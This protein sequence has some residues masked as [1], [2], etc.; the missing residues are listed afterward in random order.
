MKTDSPE[1]AK[2]NAP[3]ADKV[4]DKKVAPL[5][6]MQG[7][8]G[9]LGLLAPADKQ[10]ANDRQQRLTIITI[11]TALLI[12]IVLGVLLMEQLGF[13][14]DK[15][16][17][18]QLIILAVII[19]AVIIGRNLHRVTRLSRIENILGEAFQ[20][21]FSPQVIVD[22][23]GHA[24]IYNRVYEHWIERT[25]QHVEAALAAKF[26]ENPTIAAEFQKL[27][28]AART[29]TP[30][31]NE[32]PVIKNGKILEWRRVIVRPLPST[33][34]LVWRMEDVSERKRAEQAVREE[35]AKLVDFMAH[36]P[37]GIYSVDQN[38]RFRFVNRTLAE[39]LGCSIEE[40]TSGSVKL[41][42]VFAKK[43]GNVA[44]HAITGGGEGHLHGDTLVRSK[45]GRVF[46]VSITQTVVMNEDGKT[47]RTRSIVRDLT[48]EQ[49]WQEALSLSDQRFHR[50]FAEAPIG[51]ALIRGNMLIEECNQAFLNLIRRD[52]D[53]VIRK[54]FLEFI[55]DDQRSNMED[56]LHVVL[57]GK[58]IVKPL[59]L[60]GMGDLQAV[61]FVYA[62]PFALLA[63]STAEQENGLMLYFI[64]YTEQKRIEAQLAHSVKLQAIGQLAGGVA[65]DF[66][67]LLTAMIG[68]CDLLLQRHK[69]GDQSFADI[70]QIK[71]NGNRAA[72]LVRQLLAFSRQQTL[73]PKILNVT[74]VLAELANLLRRLIGANVEL[75]MVHARDVGLI[76]ADQGQLEQ[77]IINLVVNARDA[78][79]QGGTVSITTSAHHQ[80]SAITRGQDVMAPGDYVRIEVKDQGIGIPRENLQRIFEPFFSTK[81]VGSGT[82]LGLST[83]YGIVRQTGGFVEVDSVVNKG[84]SFIVYLPIYV[85]KDKPSQIA[86]E[87]KK[88]KK[89]SDLT[90]V[91]T[92]LLVED[93]DA[94]RVF[95]ARALRNKGYHVLEARGGE[96]ALAIVEEQGNNIDLMISDVVMPGM[97][98]PTLVRQVIAKRPDA[99]VIF[100]SGYT[101]DRFREQLKEGEVVHFLSKPFSLKQLASK[102]KEVLTG[103]VEE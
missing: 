23:D 38:G 1:P 95:G 91:G 56:R 66:N 58:D 22:A 74:D 29:G 60:R 99:K 48:P 37:V 52:K 79:P 46:P 36:A 63:S 45:N 49:S 34:Y 54:N 75:K 21:A 39:W 64:D 17:A 83:V 77:V 12:T 102:V 25:G 4:A 57:A 72:N 70:M 32:L 68:F 65:H 73:Q 98:G 19:L 2:K 20:A 27:R 59:E 11:S 55:P 90:G 5:A 33:G 94:V 28:K 88:E 86:V 76:K 40:L 31:Q 7:D 69:P 53:A 93:E 80:E 9:T 6:K 100:I 97:D 50:L 103:E 84:S 71:Q 89:S 13:S 78:M 62:K 87:E 10:D 16:I 18:G 82:G 81:E 3:A 30:T 47:L 26:G 67:N 35:Q 61:V 43:M 24:I 41:H 85:E 96:E 44:P 101:E 92:I 42:D 8:E 15:G 14:P 51:V